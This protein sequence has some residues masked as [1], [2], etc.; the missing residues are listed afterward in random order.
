MKSLYSNQIIEFS[1]CVLILLFNVLLINQNWNEIPDFKK[2]IHYLSRYMF[3]TSI[4]NLNVKFS[5]HD[6][7][8]VSKG[9]TTG[10][11]KTMSGHKGDMI[12]MLQNKRR[13]EGWRKAKWTSIQ[14]SSYG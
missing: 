3:W 12:N 14:G 7:N 1:Q 6:T 13:R 11:I 8:L 4:L 9:F 10:L 5:T 2:S